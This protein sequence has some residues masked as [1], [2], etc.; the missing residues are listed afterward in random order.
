LQDSEIGTCNVIIERHENQNKS[1]EIMASCTPNT[2]TDVSVD[3]DDPV[4]GAVAKTCALIAALASLAWVYPQG[5][6]KNNL[7]IPFWKDDHTSA[8]NQTITKSF[9]KEGSTFIHAH[10]SDPGE[11]WP[12]VY[13]KAYAK[14]QNGSEICD[15]SLL[16][17]IK[18]PGNGVTALMRLT[19][20]KDS[21]TT[22]VSYTHATASYANG[23]AIYNDIVSKY[24]GAGTNS[25]YQVKYPGTAWTT[26]GNPGL[27]ITANHEYSILG[28]YTKSNVQYIVLRNPKGASPPSS[29]LLD[30][31]ASWQVSYKNYQHGNAV[32]GAT[33]KTVPLSNGTFALKLDAF[34]SYFNAFGFVK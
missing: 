19:G 27:G 32:T 29:G 10:S 16:A 15:M 21:D 24:V 7:T 14:W 33:T 4:M 2:G 5:I 34:K 23:S 30:N 1:E 8:G 13:E 20:W 18:W 22:G 25:S 17:S 31:S 26:A 12:A 6:M 28:V 11:I 3:Y 9:W